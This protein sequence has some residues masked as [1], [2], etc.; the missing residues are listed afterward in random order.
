MN[1]RFWSNTELVCF[2]V[3]TGLTQRHFCILLVTQPKCRQLRIYV[4]G[5]SGWWTENRTQ[6]LV[7]EKRAQQLVD[8]QQ[9]TVVCVLSRMARNKGKINAVYSTYLVIK[10]VM[11]ITYPSK[12]PVTWMANLKSC[13]QYKDKYCVIYVAYW[14]FVQGSK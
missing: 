10:F 1:F 9:T 14:P 6:Q 3:A 5:R 8:W 4:N 13:F 12:I 11:W 7:A 2:I